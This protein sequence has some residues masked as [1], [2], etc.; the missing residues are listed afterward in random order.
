MGLMQEAQSKT[1]FEVQL[2]AG[3]IDLDGGPFTGFSMTLSQDTSGTYQALL[4]TTRSW[5]VRKDMLDCGVIGEMA[6]N[7]VKAEK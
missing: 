6:S 7:R 4:K 3:P 5:I 2:Y 1:L